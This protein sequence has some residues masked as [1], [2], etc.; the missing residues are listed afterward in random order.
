[1]KQATDQAS[2]LAQ[3]IIDGRLALAR[4]RKTHPQPRLTIPLADQKLI[5]QVTEMQNLSDE[6]QT[7][8][9]QLQGVKERV[10]TGA[11]E[12]ETMRVERAEA[13]KAV[14][15]SRMDEDDGRLI[16]LYD[17]CVLTHRYS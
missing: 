17:W 12:V 2:I 13:D 6:V 9:K 8:N 1:M 16:P 11:M 4:L 10:K 5:D 7:I 15:L 14:K 3:K